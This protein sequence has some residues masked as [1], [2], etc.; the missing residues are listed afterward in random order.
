MY[1]AISI[2]FNNQ[3]AIAIH[4]DKLFLHVVSNIQIYIYI[5]VGV[6]FATLLKTNNKTLPFM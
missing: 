2:N 6:R 4:I 3:H 1:A 5:G